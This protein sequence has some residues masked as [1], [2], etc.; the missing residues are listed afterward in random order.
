MKLSG[1]KQQW[2]VNGKKGGSQAV[3]AK[4]A[5]LG[6]K[7]KIGCFQPIMAGQTCQTSRTQI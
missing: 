3:E 7:K 2:S 4:T 5:D 1:Q 6:V